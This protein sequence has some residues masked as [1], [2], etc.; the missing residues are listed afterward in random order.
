MVLKKLNRFVL[1]E[2]VNILTTQRGSKG[3][4]ARS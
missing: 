1:G 3:D 2:G 4:F